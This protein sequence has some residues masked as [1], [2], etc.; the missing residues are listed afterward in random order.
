MRNLLL[1]RSLS[2]IV[3]LEKGV[4]GAFFRNRRDFAVAGDDGGC[5]GQGQEPIVDGLDNFALVSAGQVGPADRA[6]EKGVPGEQQLLGREVEAD[7][8]LGVAG[9]V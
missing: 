3:S 7:A 2:S 5:V 1:L 4:V 9:S 6:S 8:A